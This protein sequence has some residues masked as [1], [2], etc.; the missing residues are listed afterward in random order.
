MEQSEERG[1]VGL[2]CPRLL[3]G[4]E[5]GRKIGGTKKMALS[6]IVTFLTIIIFLVSKMV[7]SG[8]TGHRQTSPP[9]HADA[10]R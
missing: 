3:A 1:C 5:K 7:R 4:G 2:R 6:N 8:R 9:P 10:L